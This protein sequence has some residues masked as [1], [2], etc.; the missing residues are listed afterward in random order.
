[1]RLFAALAPPPTVVDAVAQ[2][3]E[4]AR[5]TGVELRWTRPDQW[6]LTLGFYANVEQEQLAGLCVRLDRVARRHAPLALQLVGGGR[7]DGRVLWL[8]VRGDRRPLGRLAFA[9]VAAAARE[10]IAVED[11]AYRPHL[12]IG[13]A[14]QPTDL[15][16][17]VAALAAWESPP[18]QAADLTLFR[19]HLGAKPWYEVLQVWTIGTPERPRLP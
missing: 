7:F 10:G 8:G 15:R 11:R 14:R 16:P 12:T 18:W 13:R 5:S 2:A 19:S 4:R 1:M 9:T 6:H 3:I 17:T